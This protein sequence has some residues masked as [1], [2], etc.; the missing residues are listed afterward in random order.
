MAKQKKQKK[1]NKSN[2]RRTEKPPVFPK[3]NAIILAICLLIQALCIIY[4]VNYSTKPKD[5]IKDYTVTVEPQNDGTLNIRYDLQWQAVAEE[6]LTWVEIG[7]ANP[8]FTIIDYSVSP[9]VKE[10][11]PI[12]DTDFYA[13]RLDFAESYSDG[14]I[15][16]FSFTVNQSDMLCD[17]FQGYFYRFVPSWFNEIPVE[18]YNFRWKYSDQRKSTSEAPIIDGYH[19]WTGSLDCGEYREISVYYSPD[20][21]KDCKTME[22]TYF[23]GSAAFNG[24]ENDKEAVAILAGFVCFIL[25]MFEIFFFD[26]IVSYSRGKGFLTSNGYHIHKNGRQ[27]REYIRAYGTSYVS[28]RGHQIGRAHV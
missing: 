8:N 20:A 26:S 23:D 1:E 18:S 14:E 9:T 27:S 28:G 16:D 4:A 22:Y 13:V 17:D 3:Q 6:P 19:T 2:F 10:Y 24:L 11:A 21:F 5:I 25:L 7:M 15:V 12:I